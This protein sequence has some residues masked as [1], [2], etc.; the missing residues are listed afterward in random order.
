MSSTGTARSSG[1]SCRLRTAIFRAVVGDLTEVRAA[2]EQTVN[3]EVASVGSYR[4][5]GAL[6]TFQ[7]K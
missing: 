1:L 7:I 3:A 5:G 4:A 2:F 6:G